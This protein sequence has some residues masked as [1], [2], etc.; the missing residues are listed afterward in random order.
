MASTSI[1]AS[2]SLSG[3]PPPWPAHPGVKWLRAAA[4]PVLLIAAG[5]AVWQVVVSSVSINPQLLPGPG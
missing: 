5:L 2:T 1:M 3:Q 4:P